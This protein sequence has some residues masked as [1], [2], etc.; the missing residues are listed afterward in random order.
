MIIID[1]HQD[2]AWNM[3]TFGRDYT[4]SAH[5]TRHRERGTETPIHNDDTLLGWPEYQQGQ[6]A[7][8]FATLF[9]A[10]IRRKLG[11]WDTQHYVD[12]AQAD[13][14]YSAQLD[15]YHRLVDENPD[16]F[17]LIR[18]QVDLGD[19]LSHWEPASDDTHPVGLLVLMEG[20]E[21]VRTPSELEE[22]WVRG[23]RIIGPAWAGTRFCGG[24]R[25]PG[26]LTKEGYALLEGMAD[27]GF[28]LDISH[29]DEAAVLQSL[30]EY[31]GTIIASHANAAALLK[32]SGSNRHLSNRVIRGL[33]DRDGVIGV[34]P[35]N[36]FLVP[37]WTPSDGREQ[38][39][40]RHIAT[41]IDHNCQLAG[42]ARHVGIGSDFDGG[43][44]LQKAPAE[45]DSIADLQKLAPIL[46][47][48]GYAEIDIAAILGQNWFELLQSNLPEG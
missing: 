18:T 40:L 6:I 10:P 4:L 16:K 34:V 7:V 45:I 42:D 31:P 43:F 23:V 37:G 2:L 38:V 26:P 1:A 11:D 48:K 14:R 44:G 17:R 36:R 21:G 5:E 28:T 20:A 8:I 32:G 3:L 12:A 33:I 27:L 30:D 19:L 24:T 35:Y 9:A 46:A 22:W 25:E 13:M 47:Q 29:M 15:A 41:Q 39:T